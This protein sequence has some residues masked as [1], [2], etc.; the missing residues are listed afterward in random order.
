M[1]NDFKYLNLPLIRS[2]TEMTKISIFITLSLTTLSCKIVIDK[3]LPKTKGFIENT[4]DFVIEH[5]DNNVIEL[6]FIYDSLVTQIPDDS[7]ESLILAESLKKR[8][9][10]VINWDRGNHPRGP[11]FVNLTLQKENCIC[12]VTK[13]YYSTYSDTLYEMAERIACNDSLIF[14]KKIKS[15]AQIPSTK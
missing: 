1:A 10:K 7:L 6:P 11:R 13:F 14:Y 4:I 12:E 9:F 15:S 2:L 5:K 8:G 3:N